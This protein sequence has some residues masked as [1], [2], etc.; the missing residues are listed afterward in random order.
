MHTSR[1]CLAKY[2]GSLALGN[3]RHRTISPEPL[4]V[5]FARALGDIRSLHARAEIARG[6]MVKNSAVISARCTCA[7]RG[8]EHTARLDGVK[9]LLLLFLLLRPPLLVGLISRCSCSRVDNPMASKLAKLVMT[10]GV[11]VSEANSLS[12]RSTCRTCW[13]SSTFN[14]FSDCSE[15][16]W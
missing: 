15:R 12:V 4:L 16:G 6:H 5:L 14:V 1:G 13:N 11:P 8:A 3:G 9:E 7:R 10:L 2:L